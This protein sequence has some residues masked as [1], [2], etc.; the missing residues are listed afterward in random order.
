M[1]TPR[2][3]TAAGARQM[4]LSPFRVNGRPH[5]MLLVFY[6]ALN[7]VVLV[8]ALFHFP[9]VGYDAWPH[10]Q[11]IQVLAKGRL[12]LPSET[13][14]YFSPPLAY[15]VPALLDTT[16][17]PFR[18]V[19]KFAQL[20]NVMWSLLL[21][22]GLLRLCDL[23][24]PGSRL[25][26]PVALGLLGMLPVYYKTFA[27]VRPEPLLACL[28]VWAAGGI[29]RLFAKG[30][31]ALPGVGLLGLSFG[32]LL[33]TRQQA[34]LW[35]TGAALVV[36]LGV[37]RPA[38]SRYRLAQSGLLA[39]A[40]GLALGGWFYLHLYRVYGSL[41]TFNRPSGS[42]SLANY[43]ASFY[44]GVGGAALFRDPVRPSFRLE[45]W[46]KLY[47]ETWGDHESYFLV[48]GRDTRSGDFVAGNLLEKAL[49][50]GVPPWM[51]TNR[52][53][54]NGYLGRVNLVSLLPSALLVAGLMAGVAALAQVAFHPVRPSSDR[55]RAALALL[56]VVSIIGYL[57]LL[58]RY[59]T[60]TGDTIKATYLIHVF[61]LAA[62]L[63][64]DLLD[65]LNRRSPGAGRAAMI[66]LAA[67]AVHDAGAFV[68]RYGVWP[69]W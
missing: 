51:D 62:V 19:M 9:I 53:R 15:L 21:T 35:L 60:D 65:R 26:K 67:I 6:V 47:A 69:R 10:F 56:A 57:A 61:P 25:L 22:F 8:N 50:P 44:W 27:F 11:Y 38:G 36:G 31:A 32:L 46:P 14:E 58:V 39:L 20:L 34:V 18:Y 4:L 55:A 29:V 24:R 5:L 59:A 52:Y 54:I 33:L 23:T 37:W 2:W 12:P 40:I 41:A 13:T 45:L 64:A 16:G 1:T 28:A 68:T 17:L 3:A 48:Y 66:L 43:P 42:F 63:A 49:R 30:D 7:G